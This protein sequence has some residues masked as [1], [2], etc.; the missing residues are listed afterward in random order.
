MEVFVFK[1]QRLC[2]VRI[3]H[4][5][6]L[7]DPG[8][9]FDALPA[10]DQE[11]KLRS[12]NTH[13]WLDIQADK[14]TQQLLKDFRL[15]FKKTNTGFRILAQVETTDQALI[16]LEGMKLVFLF[17]LKNGI[18]GNTD[19]PINVIKNGHPTT[20][21]FGNEFSWSNGGN[22]PS[23]ALPA[24]SDTATTDNCRELDEEYDTRFI[25]QFE[26]TSRVGMGSF[27]LLNGSG[28]IQDRVFELHI[29]KI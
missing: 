22:F 14:A 16:D 28:A 19:L 2:E 8:T 20:Y 9:S 26:I 4:H 15:V 11:R 17:N 25:G 1:Y 13:R 27:S 24:G 29:K 18:S 3:L 10:A 23:L 6:L 5:Y 21:V 12:Y 7:D